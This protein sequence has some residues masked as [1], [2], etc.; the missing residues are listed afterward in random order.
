MKNKDL[1]HFIM[2][3]VKCFIILLVM[4]I[5]LPKAMDYLLENLISNTRIYKNSI[6]VYKL[7]DKNYKLVYN[8]VLT[9]YLFFRF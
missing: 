2:L 6:V 5:L 4:G 7:V 9:F 3:T 8:Y 1:W